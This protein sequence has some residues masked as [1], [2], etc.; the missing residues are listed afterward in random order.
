MEV[1]LGCLG[2]GDTMK[3][4]FPKFLKPSHPESHLPVALVHVIPEIKQH[5]SKK[6]MFLF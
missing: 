3:H 6:K 4:T 1:F 2:M 5:N